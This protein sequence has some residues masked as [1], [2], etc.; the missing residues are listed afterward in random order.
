MLLDPPLPHIDILEQTCRAGVAGHFRIVHE[1]DLHA[2]KD[3]GKEIQVVVK[4]GKVSEHWVMEQVCRYS[5]ALILFDQRSRSAELP[6][7]PW[8]LEVQAVH[9]KDRIDR[10]I[11]QYRQLFDDPSAL[12]FMRRQSLDQYHRYCNQVTRK[13]LLRAITDQGPKQSAIGT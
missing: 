12:S 2:F 1:K 13:N 5:R 3:G 8:C 11:Q 7:Y 10:L 9:S 6:A 4:S